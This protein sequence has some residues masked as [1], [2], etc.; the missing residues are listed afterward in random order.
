[1]KENKNINSSQK[2]EIVEDIAIRK[3]WHPGFPRQTTSWTGK[4]IDIPITEVVIHGTAGLGTYEFIRD[5]GRR[6]EYIKGIALFHFLIE[7][8][9][10]MIRQIEPLD[11]WFYHS[12]SGKHDSETVGIELENPHKVNGVPYLDRQYNQ[13]IW[14]LFDYLLPTFP[15][16]T[17]IVSH[18]YNS[19]KYSNKPKSFCPGPNFEWKRLEE[20]LRVRN[21]FF[22]REDIEY[23]ELQNPYIK[24][25]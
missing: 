19:S 15:T 5:G 12:S 22:S 4:V 14:L 25:E 18:N 8:D 10:D 13:L 16:I 7:Y 6:E 21:I 2:Y 17:R 23:I 20:G 24:S 9:I 1:M 3:K 11:K